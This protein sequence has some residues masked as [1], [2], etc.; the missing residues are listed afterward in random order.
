MVKSRTLKS[1]LRE[2]VDKDQTIDFMS[3]DVEGHE[4]QVLL[5]NDWQA[6]RPKVLCIEATLP[7]TNELCHQS[8]N[9]ILTENGY[10]FAYF[11]GVNRFY[12]ANEASHLLARFSAPVNVLD[13]FQTN[14]TATLREENAVLKEF[15]EAITGQSFKSGAEPKETLQFPARCASWLARGINRFR[16]PEANPAQKRSA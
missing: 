9:P 5:S 11:D 6:F 10:E 7:F 14:A 15:Y 12:V 2:H 16:T 1:V 3:I 13:Y 8:W 4:K